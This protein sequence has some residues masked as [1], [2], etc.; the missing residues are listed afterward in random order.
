[1]AKKKLYIIRHG[2]TDYNKRGIV[3]G[4]GIDAPL[5]DLG[6]EQAR[7]SF[8]S[9]GH[10]KF[11]KIYTSELQRTHQSISHFIDVGIPHQILPGLNEI[12]WGIKEGERVS[13][14]SKTYY[15]QLAQSWKNG[16][17]DRAI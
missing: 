1:M 2:Q 14:N 3:Q 5:N 11:D 16:D 15:A 10:I 8:E 6:R 12:S 4:S 13:A 7:A 17:L 9:N